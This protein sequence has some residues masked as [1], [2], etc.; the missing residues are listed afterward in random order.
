MKRL[1]IAARIMLWNLAI[2]AALEMIFGATMWF[3]VRHNLYDLVD[4]RV[5]AQIEDLNQFLRG[6]PADAAVAELQQR[7]SERFSH[8][9]AGDYLEL[10]LLSGEMVYQSFVL[11]G[12]TAGLLPPDAVKRPLQRPVRIGGRPF[13]FL[14]QRMSANGRMF[15]VE[16]GTPAGDAAAVLRR[17]QFRLFEVGLLLWLAAGFLLYPV[18]RRIVTHSSRKESGQDGAPPS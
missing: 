13:H 3:T 7:V 1:S 6:L 2:F 8:D 12:N 15:V 9:R 17:F 4:G 18:S 11:R 10:Y 14:L 5:Q 16:M